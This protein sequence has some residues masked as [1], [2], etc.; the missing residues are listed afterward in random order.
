MRQLYSKITLAESVFFFI[1]GGVGIGFGAI[2][3]YAQGLLLS[4][5]L[6]I[7]S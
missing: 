2:P 3:C 6:V 4:L 1:D 5:N 7:P